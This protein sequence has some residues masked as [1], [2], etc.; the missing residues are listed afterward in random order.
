[1]RAIRKAIFPAATG[2]TFVAAVTDA[3]AAFNGSNYTL[4]WRI[5]DFLSHLGIAGIDTSFIDNKPSGTFVS[6]SNFHFSLQ[7]AVN[8]YSIFGGAGYLIAKYVPIPGRSYVK[9][10]AKGV[11]IGGLLGGP[12]DPAPAV[13]SP[14]SQPSAL[15]FSGS[16]AIT[17]SVTGGQYTAGLNAR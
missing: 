1:M 10:A 15:N 8:K 7:K 17:R 4:A 3:D 16:G 11:L 12:L 13:Y 2:A 14:G 6:T 5:K 9:S